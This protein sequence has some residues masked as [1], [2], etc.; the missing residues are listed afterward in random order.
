M[1]LSAIIAA[2]V[3]ISIT[4]GGFAY[5]LKIAIKTNK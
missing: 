3:A 4:W 1:S 2:I 5:C